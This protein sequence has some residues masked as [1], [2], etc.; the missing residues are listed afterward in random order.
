[1]ADE[2][3]QQ[4]TDAIVGD[5]DDRAAGTGGGAMLWIV[6]AVVMVLGAGGGFLAG[7]I[8]NAG[9]ATADAGEP[10]PAEE[11]ADRTPAKEGELAYFPIPSVTI[12]LNEQRLNRHVKATISLGVDAANA[13]EVQSVLDKRMAEVTDWL[14][15]YLSGCT[16][17]D[18]RGPKNLRRI[19]REISEALNSRFWG[20][21]KPKIEKVLLTEWHVQ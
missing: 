5:G 12:N 10:T 15:I 9:P 8:L 11:P 19:Q 21:Q 14:N 2:N 7:R 1:M 13:D 6:V 17:E 16:L 20:E 4:L 18:V 3:E